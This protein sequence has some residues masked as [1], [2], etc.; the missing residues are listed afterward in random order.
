MAERRFTDKDI[1]EAVRKV[2]QRAEKQQKQQPSQEEHTMIKE[3][4][5]QSLLNKLAERVSHTDDNPFPPIP[6]S[7][8]GENTQMVGSSGSLTDEQVEEL[9]AL[10][11]S[12]RVQWSADKL[13]TRFKLPPK[14]VE[15]LLRYVAVPDVVDHTSEG[16]V[17]NREASI[18]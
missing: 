17:V 1:D 2:K 10:H 7:S 3:G 6:P 5:F 9:V 18:R 13:A 12:D 8:S 15:S 16:Y 14:D 11:K 4:D